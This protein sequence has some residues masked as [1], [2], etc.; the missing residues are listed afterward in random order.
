MKKK[1]GIAFTL[2][3]LSLIGIIVFQGYWTV[4]AYRVNKK[5]FDNDID[6]AMTRAMDSCKRDYFDS[7]RV[8]IIK[9]ISAPDYVIR[10]DTTTAPDSI[11]TTYDIRISD[12]VQSIAAMANNPYTVRKPILDFYK[13]KIK[14]KG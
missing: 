6:S 13:R 12:K 11:N 3:A 7:I 10:L 4:N 5:Q 2:I 9:R 8:A 1:L 14:Y